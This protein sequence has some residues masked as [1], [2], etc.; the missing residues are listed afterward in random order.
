ML[1]I[2]NIGPA[3]PLRGGIANFNLALTRAL[4]K[5]GHDV[6][7]QSFSLQYPG[8]LFPGKTQFEEGTP[9]ENIRI[10]SEISSVNPFSWFRVARKILSNKPDLAIVHYWMPFMAPSQG[11]IARKLRKNGVKVIAITHNVIPH[12]KRPGDKILTKYFINSCD[13]FIALA[14]SVEEDIK[15]I[16]KDALTTFVPHPVYDIFG[17]IVSR[18]NARSFLKISPDKKLVLFFGIIRDYKGLDILLETMAYKSLADLDVHLLIAGEFYGDKE[19]YL[20][21]IAEKNLGQRIIIVDNYIPSDEVKY[22]FCSADL[23]A[24][25]YKSATQSGVAQIAYHFERPMLVTNVGGLAE[26]VPNGK[27]GYVTSQNPEEIASCISDFYLNNRENEFSEN[28]RNEKHR[29]SWDSMVEA[30]E[31]VFYS[32]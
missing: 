16:K 19:K 27:V 28:V 24:Q 26:I 20:K 29:F 13:A 2:V 12:E 18:E 32:L 4:I 21:I 7:I 6:T 5:K 1:K 30:V 8:F 31:K 14:K 17:E 23:I 9:P 10:Y 25:T 15:T 11:K 3:Y 22:Y